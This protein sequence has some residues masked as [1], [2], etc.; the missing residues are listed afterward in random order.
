MPQT[1]CPNE[2]FIASRKWTKTCDEQHGAVQEQEEFSLFIQMKKFEVE[3]DKIRKV[4][5][6]VS[7]RS[8]D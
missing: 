4:R 8:E 6:K 5:G 3:C 2:S 7:K 1:V